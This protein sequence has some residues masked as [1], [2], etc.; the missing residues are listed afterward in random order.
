MEIDNNVLERII[1]KRL[2]ELRASNNLTFAELALKL[3]VH[4]ETIRRYEKDPK[5]MSIDMFL[6]LL[7]IYG[8]ETNIFF[9]EIYGKM[10]LN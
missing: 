8:Y 6:R 7:D 1:A 3:N 2:K 9:N 10:P 4:R 5:S